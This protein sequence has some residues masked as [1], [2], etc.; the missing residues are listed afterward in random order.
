MLMENWRKKKKIQVD[1]KIL[2]VNR[3][4]QVVDK[5]AKVNR[6]TRVVRKITDRMATMET[7]MQHRLQQLQTQGM[8]PM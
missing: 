2:V 1:R 4:I 3:I 6:T 5:A 8:L 7:E